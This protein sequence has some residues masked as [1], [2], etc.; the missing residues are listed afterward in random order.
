MNSGFSSNRLQGSRLRRQCARAGCATP[1]VTTLR[2]E[3]TLRQAWLVDLDEA[4]A[5]TQGDLCHRHAE[6]L[7]LPRG[8]KLH[9]ER[10]D[11]ESSPAEPPA[12]LVTKSSRRTRVRARPAATEP[13]VEPV[14]PVEPVEIEPVVAPDQLPGLEPAAARNGN[15]S[16]PAQ[17]GANDSDEEVDT[18]ALNAVLDARTPLLQRAFRNAQGR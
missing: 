1:A 18:A 5:R 4:A 2:F 12:T 13:E 14:E 7:V 3:P 17:F 8:W 9:D 10:S 16:V 6:A 15:G 11:R